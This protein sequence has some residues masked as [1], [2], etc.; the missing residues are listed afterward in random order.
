MSAARAAEEFVAG[1]DHVLRPGALGGRVLGGDG[2]ERA[3]LVSWDRPLTPICSALSPS[4]RSALRFSTRGEFTV[5]GALPGSTLR[6]SAL[7]PS[8]PEP[9]ST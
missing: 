3:V 8:A 1:T 4:S 7:E 9:L 2:V 5:I 6:S